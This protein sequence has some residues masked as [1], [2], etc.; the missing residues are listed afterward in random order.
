MI[1]DA[2]FPIGTGIPCARS[3]RWPSSI[4]HCWTYRPTLGLVQMRVQHRPFQSSASLCACRT[5]PETNRVNVHM[6][7][8]RA[9]VDGSHE[10]P[11]IRDVRGDRGSSK[12]S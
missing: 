7:R 2:R 4:F 9:N 11:M 8:L 1:W 5:V 3:S 10:A 6:G 12:Q